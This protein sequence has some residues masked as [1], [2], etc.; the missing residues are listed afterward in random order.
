VDVWLPWITEGEHVAVIPDGVELVERVTG[1][2]KPLCCW[3]LTVDVAL[4]PA[5][6]ETLHGYADRE[7]SGLVPVKNSVMFAAPP[8]LAFNA[9][10]FQF[11]SSVDS[12]EKWLYET[13]EV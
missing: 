5:R 9:A 7:K 1:P 13:E 11:A 4:P 8:S 12:K 10:R 2:W 3:R 6:K